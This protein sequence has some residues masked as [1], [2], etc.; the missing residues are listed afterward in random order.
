M[1]GLQH[2][3]WAPTGGG[4]E[5]IR[6][7]G[8][9]EIWEGDGGTGEE[10]VGGKKGSWILEEDDLLRGA[11]ERHGARNWTAISGEVWGRCNQLNLG[12]HCRPFTLEEDAVIVDAHA[13]WQVQQQVATIACLLHGLIDNSIKN[14]QNSM[15]CCNR[16]AAAIVSYQ[17]L[18]LTKGEEDT[19]DE[20]VVVPTA[21]PLSA[22]KRLC[23]EH[24]LRHPTL[25]HR[26]PSAHPMSPSP[27]PSPRPHTR[28]ERRAS[29][30]A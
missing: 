3:P 12:V 29:W 30:L 22:A 10:G 16:R 11:V 4:G 6:K 17:S 14:H 2:I 24:L 20:S 25:P 23:V 7:S 26:C 8:R 21:P 28:S 18:D 15:L 19:S 13:K 1:V 27:P 9:I 5:G